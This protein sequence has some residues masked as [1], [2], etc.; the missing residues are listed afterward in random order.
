MKKN[1]AEVIKIGGAL[2]AFI[3]GS[4]FATGQELL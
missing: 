4:G 2:V 3:V 1:V